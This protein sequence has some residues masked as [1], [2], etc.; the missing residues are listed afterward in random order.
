MALVT[1][2]PWGTQIGPFSLSQYLVLPNN[3]LEYVPKFSGDAN[4]NPDDHIKEIIV[5]CGILGV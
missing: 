3:S 1:S 2:Q 5:A 4:Q